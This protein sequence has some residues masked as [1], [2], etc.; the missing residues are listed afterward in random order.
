MR[1]YSAAIWQIIIVNVL[2]YSYYVNLFILWEKRN[3]DGEWN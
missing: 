1:Y 3:T 2:Y